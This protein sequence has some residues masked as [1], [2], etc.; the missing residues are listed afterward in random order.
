MGKGGGGDDVR[1]VHT[2]FIMLSS[3]S[4]LSDGW[5]IFFYSLFSFNGSFVRCFCVFLMKE[6]F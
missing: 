4:S 1:T 6:S 5:W 2:S 3:K